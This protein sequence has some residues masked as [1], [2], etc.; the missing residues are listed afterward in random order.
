MRHE[1]SE[2][3]RNNVNAHTNFVDPETGHQRLSTLL[4]LLLLLLLLFS[5]LLLSDFRFPKAL[6]F[7]NRW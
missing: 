3:C 2:I 6:S 1:I 4:L 7:L 5:G